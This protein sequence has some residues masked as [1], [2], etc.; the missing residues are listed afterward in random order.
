MKKANVIIIT[1]LL[2]IIAGLVIYIVYNQSANKTLSEDNTNVISKVEEESKDINDYEHLITSTRTNPIEKDGIEAKSINIRK[3]ADQLEITTI[4]KNNT[5][6]VVNGYDIEIDLTDDN[7]NTVTTISDNTR[8][9]ID[10]GQSIEIKNYVMD[11]ENPER[12]SNA[13]ITY[14]Q[15][16]HA[17][18]LIEQNMDSVV[19]D[20]N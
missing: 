16:S 17:G 15:K 2:L 6:E 4:L 11:L 14:L 5:S 9:Q 7:G 19:I 13:K 10:S 20:D 12:I 3:L 1:I 18:D 8:T